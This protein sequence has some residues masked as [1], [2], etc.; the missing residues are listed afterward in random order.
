MRPPL[1]THAHIK[2]DIAPHELDALD[3]YVVA[4]TRT[5]AE[6]QTV[7]HRD[8]QTTVWGLGCHP[9][10]ARASK[11][12]DADT[13]EQL[14]ATAAL[15]G[16][17]GLDGGSRVPMDLQTANLATI[18][19]TLE[20]TPLVAS[21]H[22]AGATRQLVS[23]LEQHAPPGLVLH[24]WRGTREETACAVELG[25]YFS[26]NSRD[27]KNPSVV[28]VAP[29]DRIL[30][31]TDHPAGDRS[32]PPPR[33]PGHMPKITSAL[34]GAWATTP[35]EVRAQVWRNWRTVTLATQ[36]ADRLPPAFQLELLRA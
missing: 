9:G 36:T 19:R 8:D 30:T 18:L 34:A 25:C 17:V 16:E 24:W 20:R 22:S 23:L 2:P 12:F 6:Y 28:G 14:M 3:A 5:P 11:A 31:E 15:I 1:D 4:V 26:V 35:D 33:R 21:L 10:L 7:Q 27:L 32:E 13:F 29:R